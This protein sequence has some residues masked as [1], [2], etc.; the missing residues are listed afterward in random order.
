MKVGGALG[1]TFC[2]FALTEKSYSLWAYAAAGR[3]SNAIARFAQNTPQVAHLR[4]H[5]WCLL[6]AALT[7]N[8][9]VKQIGWK[10]A[11]GL[12]PRRFV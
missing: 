8:N 10:P 11:R 4:V 5:A 9:C 3:P 2:A 12:G 1:S 6:V 7:T